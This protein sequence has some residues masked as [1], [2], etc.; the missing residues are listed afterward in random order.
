M[1]ELHQAVMRNLNKSVG[2]EV[3]DDVV[4]GKVMEILRQNPVNL[5]S[6]VGLIT[7]PSNQKT[8]HKK[9]N[10]YDDVFSKKSEQNKPNI[11]YMANEYSYEVLTKRTLTIFQES[12][13]SF[14]SYFT[15]STCKC[16]FFWWS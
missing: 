7:V 9:L 10:K 8:G 4:W 15:I 12:A 1:E 6:F 14:I 11:D 3:S 2:H 5:Y 13:R 16:G